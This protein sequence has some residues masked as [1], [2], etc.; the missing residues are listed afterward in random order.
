[1]ACAIVF[2]SC[3]NNS[4][5]AS[6]SI[7][8]QSG[9]MFAPKE[10]TSSLTDEQRKA[11][12]EQKH[13]EFLPISIDEL[14]A[15]N[16]VNFSVLPPAY[17]EDITESISDKIASKMIQIAAQNGISGLST[18]P[19]LAFVAR[20]DAKDRSV[21]G[22]APQKA[23]VKYEITFYTGN[24]I[25][26]D[27]YASCSQEITGVGSNFADATGKA[28]NELQNNS[29][30]QKM[31]A[32]ASK[33]AISWYSS[34]ANVSNLVD[35]FVSERDYPL[36]MALLSSV[37]ENAKATYTYASK[38]DKEVSDMF[39]EEKATELLGAMQGAVAAAGDE[40]SPEIGA[41]LQLIPARSNA[42][43]TAQNVYNSYI[44]RVQNVRDTESERAFRLEME[45]L[46]VEKIKAPYE[47]QASIAKINAD[48]RVAA[49]QARNTGGFLGLGKFWD[50]SF[51][52]VNR[53]FDSA[54]F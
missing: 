17:T 41:Y 21:T 37:P 35:K 22:T 39:F 16:G 46:A 9:T 5:K 47:A 12:I 42:Y 29:D 6:S 4:R 20:I 24:L 45:Q 40:Y 44:K 38:K 51:G 48:A 28:V 54:G 19:V 2:A 36:A 32:D 52:L 27:I 25:T 1:M 23:I 7:P 50:H 18:N 10:K 31:F 8:D 26:N 43:K 13:Q 15:M 33:K 14:I 3:G 49:A 30:F 34:T 11:A 53:L